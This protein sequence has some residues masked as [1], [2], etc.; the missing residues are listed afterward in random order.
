MQFVYSLKIIPN[1][2]QRP[3][4]AILRFVAHRIVFYHSV[5]QVGVIRFCAAAETI[6]KW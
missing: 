2:T 3:Y 6:L 1:L 5:E 4:A